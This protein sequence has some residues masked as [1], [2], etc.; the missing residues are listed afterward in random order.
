MSFP[1]ELIPIIGPIT[2]ALIAGSISFIITVLAK[3]QKTSEFR[4]SWI[5]SLRN[6]ISDLTSLLSVILSVIRIKE[7]NGESEQKIIEHMITKDSDFIKMESLATRV[8]LRLNPK[9]HKKL[10][11]LICKITDDD[12][13]FRNKEE[14]D[15][16]ISK[17]VS[18]SQIILKSEWKRVKKGEFSFRAVK[19]ISLAVF[20]SALAALLI[21]AQPYIQTLYTP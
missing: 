4:Q 5:D 10:F 14:A 20:I 19:F 13:S 11:S 7:H 21:Q 3:D 17:I 6:D 1:P 2:A 8:K 12:N 16:I 15:D 9:E 18:E